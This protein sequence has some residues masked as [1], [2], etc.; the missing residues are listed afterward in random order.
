MEGYY[1]IES[2]T[3]IIND[4]EQIREKIIYYNLR[5]EEITIFRYYG[6]V[7]EIL[8]GYSEITE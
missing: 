1:K 2:Y 4:L 3:V 6:T 7:E 8:D 5:M